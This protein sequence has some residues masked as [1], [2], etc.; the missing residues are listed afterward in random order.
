MVVGNRRL[1][2]YVCRIVV[3]LHKRPVDKR[4]KAA[5]K[6]TNKAFKGGFYPLVLCV[7]RSMRYSYLTVFR[8][9]RCYSDDVGRMRGVVIVCF[10]L[11]LKY[12]R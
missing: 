12:D 8:L 9:L 10:E 1:P 7:M 6:R 11:K 3:S 5:L 2:K 4:E